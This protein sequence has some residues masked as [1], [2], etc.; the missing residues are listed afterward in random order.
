MRKYS[1]V[2]LLCSSATFLR[3]DF[4]YTE[5]TQMTGGSMAAMMRSLGPL[6]G[7]AREPIVSTHI[8]KGNRQ[9]TVTRNTISVMDLDKET[10]TNID[11]DKKQFSVM[12]FAEMKKQM[13]EALAKMQGRQKNDV[14]TSF[15]IAAK[16]TGN[17]KT[18]Q[19]LNAKEMQLTVTTEFA[20]AKSGQSGAMDMVT[21]SWMA[22]VPGYEELREFNTKMALKL[23][24]T[25]GSGMQQIAQ[26]NPGQGNM[27]Q[28]MEELAKEMQ[29][30]D[31][32]PVESLVKMGPA[33]TMNAAAAPAPAANEAAC[34]AGSPSPQ[35]QGSTSAAGALAG[36]LGGRLGGLGGFGRKKK[37]EPAPAAQ[38]AAAGCDA[39]A[40]AA[41]GGTLMEMTMTLTSF[42]ST[43]DASKFDI[44]AG[45]KQVEARGMR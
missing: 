35:T 19:G 1:L 17:T 42:S 4:T 27:T 6:A 14:K 37:E 24:A 29:K 28:A 34:S 45:F 33:G 30:L 36:A 26:M 11:T 43:A 41:A 8:V 32:I 2:V 12:T 9:A 7:K 10:I 31:G 16:A 20:D 13:E 25:F 21:N 23:G 38:P 5:T 40:P 22:P 15:K 3:A 44:P 18:V 39:S